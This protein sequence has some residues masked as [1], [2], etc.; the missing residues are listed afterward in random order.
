MLN[1]TVGLVAGGFPELRPPHGQQ[2]ADVPY[3]DRMK[4]ELTV[5]EETTLYE[6]F[7]QALDE[8]NV[9]YTDEWR[10]MDRPVEQV[11][12]VAFYEPEDE[13]GNT[14]QQRWTY[15]HNL[16]VVTDDQRIRWHVPLEEARLADLVRAAEHGLVDGDPLRPYIVLQPP[17]GNGLLFVWA[18]FTTALSIAA[19]IEGT[20]QGIERIKRKLA[21]GKKV[22]DEHFLDWSERGGDPLAVAATLRRQ[23][24]KTDE[25][26]LLLGVQ[27]IE[28]EPLMELYGFARNDEGLWLSSEEEEA[29]LLRLLEDDALIA[30]RSGAGEVEFRNR[31]QHLLTTG[32]QAEKPWERAS[33][34]ELD[35]EDLDEGLDDLPER[36]G[37]ERGPKLPLHL[38]TFDCGCGQDACEGQVRIDVRTDVEPYG[39]RMNAVD[40]IDH[41]H[42]PFDLFATVSLQ[43]LDEADEKGRIDL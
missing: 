32:E 10:D 19:N 2:G 26:A 12:F 40:V 30:F 33:S 4:V 7:E 38:L 28:V 22:I 34:E 31:A 42:F 8:F 16:V 14:V 13:G 43:A 11:H 41:F 29:R 39:V 35:F 5:D 18:M 21:A 1:V 3:R 37:D 24:W 23:P 27:P 15:A 9:E 6:V 36:D 17:A 20:I 25:L